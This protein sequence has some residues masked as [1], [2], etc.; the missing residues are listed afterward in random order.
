MVVA[1]SGSSSGIRNKV[2]VSS[3][4]WSSVQCPVQ[5]VQVLGCCGSDDASGGS[6]YV[7][8]RVAS[9]VP[10]LLLRCCR[11]HNCICLLFFSFLGCLAA[12]EAAQQTPTGTEIT[13]LLR[14]RSSIRLILLVLQ[15]N[16]CGKR[17]NGWR[18]SCALHTPHAE[19]AERGDSTECYMESY[20]QHPYAY[21][22][23][24][25]SASP[26]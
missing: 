19:A 25:P 10:V 2:L 8:R 17:V 22:S 16:S 13:E 4:S 7:A 14:V 12:H 11:A 3:G 18:S 23:S 20:S 24:A 6:G 1:R 5:R 21:C 26:P 15:A 9:M